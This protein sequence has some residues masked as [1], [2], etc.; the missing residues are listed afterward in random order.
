MEKLGF[1]LDDGTSSSSNARR[2]TSVQELRKESIQ[3]CVASLKHACLCKD[4]NCRLGSCYKMKR[5]I[6]HARSCLKKNACAIC[7]QLI[8]LCLYHSKKCQVRE[9]QKLLL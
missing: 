3:R 5:V 9:N 8:A 1:G 2:T 7:K 4:A 6:Y